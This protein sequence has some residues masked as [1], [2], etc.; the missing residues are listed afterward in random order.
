MSERD[1]ELESI[2][3]N[4]RVLQRTAGFSEPKNTRPYILIALHETWIKLKRGSCEYFRPY[5][6]FSFTKTI[7]FVFFAT[8]AAV[9]TRFRVL[10]TKKFRTGLTSFALVQYPERVRLVQDN[11]S[12]R[13]K[14][15]Q[16][17]VYGT[18]WVYACLTSHRSHIIRRFRHWNINSK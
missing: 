9:F 17:F 13:S 11:F 6:K 8:T 12:R 16:G 1:K 10:K 18:S 4:W 5:F 14:L 3:K 2:A 7:F 15:K